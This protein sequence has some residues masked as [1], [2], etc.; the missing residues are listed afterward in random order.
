MAAE[1]FNSIGGFSVGIPSVTVVDITGNL[2]TNVN[3]PNGNVTANVV[4]ANA[5][6]YANGTVLSVSP[7]GSNTQLQYNNNGSFGGIPNVTWNGSKLSLGNVSNVSITGGINGYF[8]QTDGTGNLSWA[9]GGGGGGNGSPGGSNTQVQFNDAGTFNGSSSF[10]FNK[11]TGLVT[12]GNITSN[13]LTVSNSFTAA[14]FSGNGNGLFNIQAANIVGFIPTAQTVSNAAQP[15]ITSLGDLISLTVLGNA[16]VSGTIAAGN[17]N[18][19]DGI[20]GEFLTITGNANIQGNLN[21]PT[22]AVLKVTGNANFSGSPNINLGTLSN[23]RISGGLNGYVLTTDGLG[24]LTWSAGGGGGGNGTP[25]GSNTQIQYNDSG[26]FGG[27]AFLTFNE[28]T[29][30]LNVAGN[31]IANALTMGSGVYRFCTSNVYAAITSSTSANQVL[32][33]VEAN[34]VSAIDFA[35]I[36][37]DPL[38]SKRQVSKISSVVY[39]ATVNYNEYSSLHVNGP[40]GD[41]RVVYDAGNIITTPKVSLVVTPLS[42]NATTHKMLI[43]LYEL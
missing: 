34:S 38:G 2:V 30:T 4:Y 43:T 7:G 16:N 3:S 36:S 11:T 29:N 19:G 17:L 35:I 37:T 23:V 14:Q 28:V 25:G 10:T 41:F 9:A 33:S 22:S 27:S 13:N 39:D 12:V 26:D 20:A 5:F 24:N 31:L 6:R 40:T 1:S 32:F 18:A 42:A 21:V 8:L 15:N